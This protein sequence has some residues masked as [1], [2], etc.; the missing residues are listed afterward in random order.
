MKRVL[1]FMALAGIAICGALA[2]N[3][4]AHVLTIK[5]ASTKSFYYA[6]RACNSDPACDRYGVL[7]CSRQQVHVVI[8]NIF[9]DRNT[10]AQGRYRCTR[11][12]RVAYRTA[13]STKP[14]LTGFGKWQC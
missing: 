2:A 9:N 5:A 13:Y 3:A 10:A 8:C 1:L 14:T 4:S 11:L 12:V 6:N 7:N